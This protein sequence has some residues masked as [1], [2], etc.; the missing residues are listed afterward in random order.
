MKTIL[1]IEDNLEI[2]ENTAEILELSGYRV[3]TTDNGSG[4]VQ[5]A[6][7]TLPDIILCDIM[8]PQLD[9]YEVFQRLKE[10]PATAHIP[11]VYITAK[12]EKRDINKAMDLGANGYLCKP[13]DVE[14]LISTIRKNLDL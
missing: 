10:L 2:R 8:I 14:E 6:A 9:G 5:I 1:I 4:G 12:T 11:F 7:N 13:F 3:I